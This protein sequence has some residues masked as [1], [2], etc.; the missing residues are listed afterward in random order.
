MDRYVYFNSD[1]SRAAMVAASAGQPAKLFKMMAG[2]EGARTP[3]TPADFT[4]TDFE[5]KHDFQ[6]ADPWEVSL[7]EF[8]TEDFSSD[9]TWGFF[10]IDGVVE[11]TLVGNR[12]IPGLLR[13]VELRA[14]GLRTSF[15]PEIF[16][17]VIKLPT[18]HSSYRFTL[19]GENRLPITIKSGRIMFTLHFRRTEVRRA[20]GA[21]QRE[22]LEF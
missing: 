16:L 15:H 3:T 11:S 4:I 10:C 12:Y 7:S 17:S 14:G 9:S 8:I 1:D 22:M 2:R 20:A 21:Y 19:L 13:R 6:N 5:S 18:R